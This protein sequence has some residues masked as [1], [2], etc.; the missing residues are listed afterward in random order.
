MAVASNFTK[1]QKALEAYFE[2]VSL[3]QSWIGEPDIEWDVTP[4]E[5]PIVVKLQQRPG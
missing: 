3:R 2:N 4:Y 5:A 1:R